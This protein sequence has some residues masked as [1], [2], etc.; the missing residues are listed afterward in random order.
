MCLFLCVHCVYR[1]RP[2]ER[3]AD[4]AHSLGLTA[5]W[6]GNNC[7]CKDHCNDT[8]CFAADVD[9]TFDYGFDSTKLDGCGQEEDVQVNPL[10][11]FA[12][13]V[14]CLA[15]EAV[16]RSCNLVGFSLLLSLHRQR[17]CSAFRCP[18]PFVVHCA[19]CASG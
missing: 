14:G 10:F 13:P 8:A 15:V 16:V 9:A 2:G 5:G 7:H 11:V 1:V 6:Y 12:L 3:D 19:T 18:V 17:L 4:F